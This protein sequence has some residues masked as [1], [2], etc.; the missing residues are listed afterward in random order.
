M[1]EVLKLNANH[2]G[3]HHV[4]GVMYHKLPWFKGGSDKKSV[5]ELQKSISLNE[6]NTLYHLDLAKTYL[7]M[8][9]EEEA[10]KELEAVI[11]IT[12]PFDPVM[13]VLNKKEAYALLGK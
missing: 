8:N 11:S 5:D 9:R 13:A 2:A 7:A 6:T 1:G 3:A 12:N 4:L 10:N